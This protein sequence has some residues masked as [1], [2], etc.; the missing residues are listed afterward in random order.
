MFI[1]KILYAKKTLASAQIKTITDTIKFIITQTEQ[2]YEVHHPK[3]L[4]KT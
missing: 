2:F 4:K 3:T 1:E